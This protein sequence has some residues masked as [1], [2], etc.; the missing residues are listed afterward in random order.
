MDSEAGWVSSQSM[1]LYDYL[2]VAMT[3]G[4]AG[5]HNLERSECQPPVHR[6]SNAYTKK[7]G[8]FL[9]FTFTE[10]T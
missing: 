5:L 10:F 1:R 6:V 4:S 2:V 3:L 7:L 8:K 9:D